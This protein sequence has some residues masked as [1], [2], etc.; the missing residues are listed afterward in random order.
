MTGL[1]FGELADLDPLNK[2]T[3]SLVESSIEDYEQIRFY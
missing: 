1:S 2:E 3:E